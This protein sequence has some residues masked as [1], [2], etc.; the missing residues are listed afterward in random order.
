[1]WV[2][3]SIAL[4]ICVAAGYLF[5]TAADRKSRVLEGLLCLGSLFVCLGIAPLP[6]QILLLLCVFA[7]EQWRVAWESGHSGSSKKTS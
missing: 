2:T 1:M 3:F 5:F 7:V 4:T 6:V